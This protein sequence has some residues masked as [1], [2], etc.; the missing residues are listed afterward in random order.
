VQRAV[1]VVYTHRG[2]ARSNPHPPPSRSSGTFHSR[3]GRGGRAGVCIRALHAAY[4][5]ASSHAHQAHRLP[6]FPIPYARAPA[7][8]LTRS[9][10]H[11]GSFNA[12]LHRYARHLTPL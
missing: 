10:S 1:Q 11:H 5:V 9:G 2:C 12:H 7:V 8:R 3:V 4:R 6:A